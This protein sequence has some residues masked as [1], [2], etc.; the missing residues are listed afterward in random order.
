MLG[1]RFCELLIF[2]SIEVMFALIHCETTPCANIVVPIM[3]WQL[4][5]NGT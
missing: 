5:W 1:E 2:K 3:I 4:S